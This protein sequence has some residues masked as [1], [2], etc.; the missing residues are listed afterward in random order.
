MSKPCLSHLIFM[1]LPLGGSIWTWT[2]STLRAGTG[3]YSSRNHPVM[4]PKKDLSI[5]SLWL[6]N[7]CKATQ[8][9]RGRWEWGVACGIPGWT[10]PLSTHLWKVALH[11]HYFLWIPSLC[12]LSNLSPICAWHILQPPLAKSYSPWWGESWI[13]ASVSLVITQSWRTE[14]ILSPNSLYAYDS[15]HGHC[16][17]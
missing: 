4:V 17:N 15:T 5:L 14:H 2:L 11:S 6:W 12:T 7:W 1:G 13:L 10:P 3:F 8:N 9:L 16:Q